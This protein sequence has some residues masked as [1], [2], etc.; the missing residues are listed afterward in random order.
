MPAGFRIHRTSHFVICYNT[1]RA[2][3]RWYGSLVERLY[4]GFNTYWSHQGFELTQ[5]DMPLV[6]L[7]FNTKEVYE[8]HARGELGGNIGSA[9]GYYNLQT[10]RVST[11]DL[12]GL[13]R[14]RQDASTEARIN[15]IL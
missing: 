10:N 11:Y 7:V 14:S 3:A 13:Q 9:F 2:Y 4:F 12:T 15:R 5:L 6:G 1:S 8:Q